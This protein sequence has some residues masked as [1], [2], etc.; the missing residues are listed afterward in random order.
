MKAMFSARPPSLATLVASALAASTLFASAPAAASPIVTGIQLMEPSA[1]SLDVFSVDNLQYAISY[2]KTF[3]PAPVPLTLRITVAHGTGGGGPFVVSE[4]INNASGKD[5]TDYHISIEN[6]PNGNVFA[7][8]SNATLGGFTLDKP[9]ASGPDALSFT[10]A[11]ATGQSTTGSFWLSL[12]DPGAGNTYTLDLVQ[13]PS[14]SAVPLPL[15]A[16][17]FGSGLL[18]LGGLRRRSGA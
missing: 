15:P 4:T 3:D 5:W 16:V 18:G 17:L 6:A 1:G 13:A 7:N 12:N 10:G 2:T 8:F 14:T 11:L 9:P